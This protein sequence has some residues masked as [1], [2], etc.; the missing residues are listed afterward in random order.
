MHSV[1]CIP[2]SGRYSL[3]YTLYSTLYTAI[4]YTRDNEVHIIHNIHYTWHRVH[5][6]ECVLNRGCPFPV[7]LSTNM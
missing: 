7:V 5:G 6:K 4:H 3:H 1:Y 2:Y